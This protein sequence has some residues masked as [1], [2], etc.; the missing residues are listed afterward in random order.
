V[1]VNVHRAKT[2]FSRL[3]A[4][5]ATGEEVLIA[6]GR[7]PVAR[8]AVAG[9]EPKN[10]VPGIDKGKIWMAPDFDTLPD[11]ILDLFYK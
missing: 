11:D 8:L 1:T 10:R 9:Q 2:H 7:R 6:R 4:Q 5:A 3:A